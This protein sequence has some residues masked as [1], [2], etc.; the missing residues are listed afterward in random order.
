MTSYNVKTGNEIEKYLIEDG[1]G[2]SCINDLRRGKTI[3]E[4]KFSHG[5][6][7]EISELETETGNVIKR[8]RF[9]Q[10]GK[11]IKL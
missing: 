3:K 2:I 10:D 7:S 5:K 11:P 6:I 4:T 9:D 1:G 8:M